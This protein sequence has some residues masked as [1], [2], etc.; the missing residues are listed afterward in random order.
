[1]VRFLRELRSVVSE[2]LPPGMSISKQIRSIEYWAVRGNVAVRADTT[3]I[4]SN[5]WSIILGVATI[6]TT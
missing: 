6:P 1:M 5:K 2:Y 4:L 3:E